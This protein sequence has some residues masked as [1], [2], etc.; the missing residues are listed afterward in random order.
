M[1]TKDLEKALGLVKIAGG[2][3]VKEV[4][5]MYICDLLSLVMSK[6]RQNCAWITVQTNI[7]IVAVAHLA[8]ISCII[9]PEGI[10]VDNNTIVK[11]NDEG[12]L[13]Y[14]SQK[15]SYELAVEFSKL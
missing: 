6:A 15:T 3:T 10:A 7:N 14:Q 4:S 5:G 2:D 12:I 13:I 8:D 11:A 1:T 9:I